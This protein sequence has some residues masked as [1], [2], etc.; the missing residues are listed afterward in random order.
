MRRILIFTVALVLAACEHS[1]PKTPE[2]ALAR[3][4][5][6]IDSAD[7]RCLYK[8][9]DRDS[10]WSIQTIHKKLVEMRR[11]VEKSYPKDRRRIAYGALFEE[12][13]AA[14]AAGMFDVYCRKRR[15][16]D[17]VARG[18]GAATKVTPKGNN[19]VIVETTRGHRFE[20]FWAEERWGITPFRDE[21][22]NMKLR[23][24][25]SLKQVEINAKDFNNQRRA[26]GLNGAEIGIKKESE[27]GH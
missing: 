1:D 18:F 16:L 27:D 8:W 21:L 4:A 19:T 10:R 13:Q 7:P 14:N 11:L 22:Q 2:G 12:A 6:C 23:V 5:P 9:L 15:C 17:Q 24:F 3:I 20:M 25:D 26:G